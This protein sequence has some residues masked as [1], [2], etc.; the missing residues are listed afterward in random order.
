MILKLCQLDQFSTHPLKKEK[1]STSVCMW[2]QVLWLATRLLCQPSDYH[3]AV[4]SDEIS[5]PFSVC[6]C[7]RARQKETPASSVTALW[8]SSWIMSHVATLISCTQVRNGPEIWLCVSV[9]VYICVVCQ[10]N[11]QASPTSL[12]LTMTIIF[13]PCLVFTW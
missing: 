7:W 6:V 10:W 5:L 1:A 2:A 12:T 3:L 13:K 11:S 4:F 9:C 8:A